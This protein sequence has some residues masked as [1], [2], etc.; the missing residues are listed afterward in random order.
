MT[1]RII[2]RS[3]IQARTGLSISTIRLWERAGRFPKRIWLGENAVG[4]DEGEIE[5]W[6][7][8]RPRGPLPATNPAL[9]AAQV[10]LRERQG[11][12]EGKD[13]SAA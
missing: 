12:G 8:A 3:Q 1:R 10:V 9:K 11:A 7:T 5:A 4:W 6:L 13:L 2:R